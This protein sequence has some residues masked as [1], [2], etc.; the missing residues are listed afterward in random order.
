MDQRFACTPDAS[1]VPLAPP[2][3]ILGMEP[4]DQHT[5]IFLD[6]SGPLQQQPHHHQLGP[7][8]PLLSSVDH[9]AMASLSAEMINSV[10]CSHSGYV[11]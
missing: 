10:P 8:I 2:S 3:A 7:P 11:G 9:M 5:P 4:I 6:M 1:G